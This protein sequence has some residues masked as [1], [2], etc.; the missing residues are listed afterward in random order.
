M[1]VFALTSRSEGMPLVVLEAWAAGLPVVAS[2]V[3]GLPEMIDDGCEGRLVP[4]DDPPALARALA[5]LM[6]DPAL[7][8]RLG[9]AGRERVLRDFTWSAVASRMEAAYHQLRGE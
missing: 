1:D 3:G 9:R 6:E 5:G 4:P 8:A 2:A 7:G